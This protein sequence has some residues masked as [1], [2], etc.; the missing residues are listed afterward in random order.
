MYSELREFVGHMLKQRSIWKDGELWSSLV[1]GAAAFVALYRC[2]KAIPAVRER[3][4]EFLTVTSIVFGFVLTTLVFYIQAAGEW[5]RD[6]RVD[7]V[8]NKLVDWHVWTIVCLLLLMCLIVVL[9]LFEPFF[10]APPLWAAVTHALLAFFAA[11]A[12]FQILNHT[13][14]VRWVFR[15]RRTLIDGLDE[16]SHT[17]G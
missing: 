10:V 12:S 15:R 11:Y 17:K 3:F 2:P 14:T 5:A 16:D 13:L 7:R 9:W 1:I 6:E 4:P 8:A